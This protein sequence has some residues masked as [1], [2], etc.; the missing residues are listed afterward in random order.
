MHADRVEVSWDSAKSNWIVRI[1]SGEEA[2][3]RP[4]KVPKDADEQTLRSLAQK[5]LREEGYDQDVP[6]M[7][8]R[9]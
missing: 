5:T 6:E 1:Q 3:R 7:I 8:I 2:I 4:C 9:R